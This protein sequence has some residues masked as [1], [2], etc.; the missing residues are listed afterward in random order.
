MITL[1]QTH[2]ATSPRP[3]DARCCP[4][5]DD[6]WHR[7]ARSR[8]NQHHVR[9]AEMRDDLDMLSDIPADF[10]TAM[11]LIHELLVAAGL[12]LGPV[13]GQDIGGNDFGVVFQQA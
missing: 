3:P 5:W 8:P 7:P 4:A 1:P 13:V 11:G 6:P 12:E 9:A 10:A 2:S